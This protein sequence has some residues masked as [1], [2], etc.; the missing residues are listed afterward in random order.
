MS[1]SQSYE[2]VDCRFYDP[3]PWRGPPKGEQLWGP[4]RVTAHVSF[5]PAR[6]PPW[7][8]PRGS[9]FLLIRNSILPECYKCQHV[10][11]QLIKTEQKKLKYLKKFNF[12]MFGLIFSSSVPGLLMV[13]R[14]CYDWTTP[15]PAKQTPVC[16][17]KWQQLPL[18]AQ[19]RL[20][21]QDA[22]RMCSRMD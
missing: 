19:R 7:Q 21:F 4:G 6:P 18:R 22:A 12:W 16:S 2:S 10:E 9:Q 14:L 8:R 11:K 3:G 13:F 1:T 17:L 15:L 5:T 20:P